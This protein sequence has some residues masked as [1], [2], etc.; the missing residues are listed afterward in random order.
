MKDPDVAPMT[1]AYGAF[2]LSAHA[3]RRLGCLVYSGP[4]S[5]RLGRTTMQ[6]RLVLVGRKAAVGNGERL[7]FLFK[8][9]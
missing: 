6:L 7:H 2:K 5:H 8:S 4:L 3:V 1:D 9:G